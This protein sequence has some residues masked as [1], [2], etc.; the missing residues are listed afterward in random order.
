[1]NH[2][3]SEFTTTIPSVS[4]ASQD[5][6]S[7][8]KAAS[9]HFVHSCLAFSVSCAWLLRGFACVMYFIL[10]A[11]QTHRHTANNRVLI[12][13][14]SRVDTTSYSLLANLIHTIKHVLLYTPQTK[15]YVHLELHNVFFSN[16]LT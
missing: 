9:R 8:T 5:T 4:V 16:L 13:D 3:S 11:S 14:T 10:S 6:N 1:M 12:V 2:S 15:V 7:F